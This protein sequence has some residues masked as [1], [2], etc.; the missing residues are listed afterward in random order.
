MN[1]NKES[2]K[3][4]SYDDVISV[5]ENAKF[6]WHFYVDHDTEVKMNKFMRENSFSR[7]DALN[8]I[9]DR[10]FDEYEKRLSS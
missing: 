4:Y 8:Y 5:I 7:M 3:K 10:F 1:K 9:M 6:T 2:I